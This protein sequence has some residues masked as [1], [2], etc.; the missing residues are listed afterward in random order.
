MN[1]KIIYKDI[2]LKI[3]K[4]DD[5]DNIGKLLSIRN[6]NFVRNF[7]FNNQ[8]IDKN[9]HFIWVKSN[10]QNNTRIFYLV[11]Y[12]NI[13]IGSVI[14]SNISY[15]NKRTDWAFYISEHSIRGIGAVIEFK[16]INMLFK[17]YN[18]EKLNC[19]VLNFNQTVIKLH[20]KFG[21]DIEGLRKNHIYRN[22]QYLDCTLLALTKNK[23]K[24]II[25]PL[26]K[27]KFIY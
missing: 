9:N 11:F 25:F 14:L 24:S 18:F 26:L 13:L 17:E 2:D 5:E 3:L 22:N 15:E 16:F 27:K 4:I 6:E 7:M 20:Q 8:I 1:L 10:I 12:Q 23:W 21:F 19:E